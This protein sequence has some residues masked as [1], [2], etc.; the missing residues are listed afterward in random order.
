M[1]VYRVQPQGLGLDHRSETSNG[2]LAAGVHVF[3]SLEQLTVGVLG[4]CR[5]QIG[6]T[7]EIV[8]IECEASDLRENGD[9]EG[10]LLVSGRGAIV[11]RQPFADSESL[12]DFLRFGPDA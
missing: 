10:D 5:T 8:T 1:N 12:F 11:H 6:E 9:Y 2:N 3:G 7:P 4:W